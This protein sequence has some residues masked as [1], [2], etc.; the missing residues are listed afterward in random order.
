MKSV[1][2]HKLSSTVYK[3]QNLPTINEPDAGCVELMV[4]F[5]FYELAQA[6]RF[7]YVMHV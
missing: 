2:M 5:D 4:C 3:I 6:N 1:R 7:T